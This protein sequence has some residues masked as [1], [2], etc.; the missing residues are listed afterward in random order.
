MPSGRTHK[1]DCVQ[2]LVSEGYEVIGF[3]SRRIFMVKPIGTRLDYRRPWPRR[4]R[5]SRIRF[6]ASKSP[7]IK[8]WMIDLAGDHYALD[9]SRARELLGWS[10]RH[11]LRETRPQMATALRTDPEGFHRLNKLEGAPPHDQAATGR[12]AKTR[13]GG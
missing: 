12:A 4:A 2:P 10:P 1:V 9:I 3:D 11:S 5:G 13:T 8:P 6:P 7:F